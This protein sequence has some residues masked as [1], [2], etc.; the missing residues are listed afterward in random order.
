MTW[1]ALT[2]AAADKLDQARMLVHLIT[3][4]GAVVERP[5]PTS[6]V[7]DRCQIHQATTGFTV[8]CRLAAEPTANV[9][10]TARCRKPTIRERLHQLRRRTG[11]VPPSIRSIGVVVGHLHSL[12]ERVTNHTRGKGSCGVAIAKSRQ[13]SC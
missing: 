5:R 11:Q 3:Q 6:V 7:P 4:R 10:N 8:A 1:P 2:Q 13:P 9:Q 12:P